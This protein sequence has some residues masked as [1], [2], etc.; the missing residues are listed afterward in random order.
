MKRYRV[1][2]YF[3]LFL[4]VITLV[5][6]FQVTMYK[7]EFYGIDTNPIYNTVYWIV[8]LCLFAFNHFVLVYKIWLNLILTCLIVFIS[9]SSTM[10]LSSKII[11][12]LVQMD[13]QVT[14]YGWHFKYKWFELSL[15]GI[16]IVILTELIFGVTRRVIFKK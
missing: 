13:N 10:W 4:M 15:I 1:E 2:F 6:F 11:Q 14:P 3:L 5:L 9:V 7:T 8:I 16:M 12:A